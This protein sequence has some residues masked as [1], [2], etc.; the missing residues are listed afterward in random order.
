MLI[1][2]VEETNDIMCS[3]IPNELDEI[4]LTYYMYQSNVTN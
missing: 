1:K 3:I 4:L 2:F